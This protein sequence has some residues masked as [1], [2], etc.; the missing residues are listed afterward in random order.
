MTSADTPPKYDPAAVGKKILAE[1]VG[2]LPALWT[3]PFLIER[4]VTDCKDRREVETAE[5]ALDNLRRS[6]RVRLGE[7]ELVEPTDAALGGGRS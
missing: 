3:A 1:A 6:G 2:Q 7:D 4:I 5:R